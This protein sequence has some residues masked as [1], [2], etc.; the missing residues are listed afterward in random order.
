M[1]KTYVKPVVTRVELRPA[2]ALLAPCKATENDPWGRCMS[3]MGCIA[4]DI[5]RIEFGS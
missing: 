2:E 4:G 5:C 3:Q 1:V